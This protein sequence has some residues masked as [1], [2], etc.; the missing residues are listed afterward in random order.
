MEKEGEELATEQKALNM[1]SFEVDNIKSIDIIKSENGFSAEVR[2]VPLTKL[3]T[4]YETIVDSNVISSL[5]KAVAC[6]HHLSLIA[7]I[8]LLL[9][10]VVIIL[11]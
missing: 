8:V 11:S 1:I 7:L 10:V 2:S 5:K 6:F 9:A 4:K 3:I